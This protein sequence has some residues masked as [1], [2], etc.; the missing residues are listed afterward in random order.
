MEE[1]SVATVSE[2]RKYFS[3]RFLRF[4]AFEIIQNNV[5]LCIDIREDC[6]MYI[7]KRNA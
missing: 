4:V 2:D 3:P 6:K 5:R 1:F 7:G